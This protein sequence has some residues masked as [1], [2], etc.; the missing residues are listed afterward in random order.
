MNIR[1]LLA[2]LPAFLIAACGGDE[3]E[4]D[5]VSLPVSYSTVAV[6]DLDTAEKLTARCEADEAAFRQ[7]MAEIEAFAGTPTVENYLKPLDSLYSSAYT[8]QFHASSLS[9]VHPDPDLRSAA[10]ACDLK[11]QAFTTELGMSRPIFDAMSAIDTSGVD[12][13]ARHVLEKGL[14]SARI[15]GVDKDEATRTRIRELNDEIAAI[16][17]EFD[18]N[19]REAVKYLELDSVDDLA[20][21]PDDY[22]AA[23]QP[24][25]EGKIVLSTQYP[26]VFPFFEYA[27]R[28]DLRKEMYLLFTTRAYPENEAVLRKLIAARHELAQLAGFD[29]YAQLI[30][31]DKMSGSP[32]RVA[33]FLADLRSYTT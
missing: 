14:L 8:L 3:A 27:E 1:F 15:A 20:G 22:I 13:V 19:I 10:E 6:A 2:L 33:G 24:N 28:D 7:R 31:A 29:N 23:H 16:G 18:R 30:T 11:L 26:D 32:E 4:V 21:L 5:E 12:Q 9:G 17:Q 25:E